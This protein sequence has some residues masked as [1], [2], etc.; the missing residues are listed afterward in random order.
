MRLFSLALVAL[1][2]VASAVEA[3]D[4][5]RSAVVVKPAGA[6][7]VVG[8]G[9]HGY[10]NRD[11]VFFNNFVGYGYG[12]NLNYFP[13]QSLYLPPPPADPVLLAALQAQYQAQ[14]IAYLAALQASYSYGVGYGVGYGTGGYGCGTGAFF[15]RSRFFR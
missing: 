15:G 8:N 2:V 4:R 6:A 7:V 10:Y 12:A 3:G 13:V 9:T 14:Q 1:F 11:R 5:A